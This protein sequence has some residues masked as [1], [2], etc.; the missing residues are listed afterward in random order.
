M[1][2]HIAFPRVDYQVEVYD[3][4]PAR[5][6][7]VARSD[8]SSPFSLRAETGERHAGKGFRSA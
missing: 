4:E 3:P 6:L 5:A 2:V 8:R 7:A 1:S